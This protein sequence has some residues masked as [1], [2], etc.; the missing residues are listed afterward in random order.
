MKIK[1]KQQKIPEEWKIVRLRDLGKVSMCKRILKNQTLP[2]GDIPFFK[3]GTFGKKANAYISK[4]I[5][6][7]YREKYSFPKIGDILISASGTIGRTVIYTGEPAYFQDSNI[8]WIANNENIINNSYLSYLYKKV[9]WSTSSGTIARL[10]N[11]NVRSVTVIAPS[12]SEQNRIV[13]VLETW[14]SGIEKLKQKIS[15]KK[16]IKKGLMQNLLTGKKRLPGFSGKWKNYSV[17]ELLDYEQPTNYIVDSTD[18]DD[19]FKTPVLTA[20]KTFILGYTNEENNIF[21]KE[22]LPVV[23]FD[24]FTTANKFVNFEFKVKSSAMKI[25]KNKNENISN[26]IFI[27]GVI[28]L[29]NF[30]VGEHKRNYLSEYQYLNIKLPNIEEQ[31]AIADI[32]MAVDEEL[33]ELLR[34]QKLLEDQ[35]KYLLNNLIS[36]QIRTPE[37]L[38]ET[39]NQK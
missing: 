28:Q 27:F 23:I 19:V 22:K 35:K 7:E 14:D 13:S 30:K 36:G 12:L 6:D 4:E 32:L 26:I 21:Q 17:G 15:L 29:L 9:R 11:E 10:Y 37:N 1:N 24:D 33:E 18:Y 20:G 8:I 5:Y 16:E 25:L 38:L 31:K 3:I 39:I 34:K 2:K